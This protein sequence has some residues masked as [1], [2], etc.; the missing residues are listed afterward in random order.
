MSWSQQKER[1]QR[2]TI[3]WL[4][5]FLIFLE[6]PWWWYHHKS[7]FSI[8]SS[9]PNYTICSFAFFCD[10]FFGNVLCSFSWQKI[11]F[12][13]K[14][15]ADLYS[16]EGLHFYELNFVFAAR[17]S[18]I[19][20]LSCIHLWAFTGRWIDYEME[21]CHWRH[22]WTFGIGYWDNILNTFSMVIV[23]ITTHIITTFINMTTTIIII[24]IILVWSQ[25]TVFIWL[26]RTLDNLETADSVQ[27]CN[28]DDL[29]RRHHHLHLHR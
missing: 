18:F 19:F 27:L 20:L 4:C 10:R 17:S 5:L 12:L 14:R 29:R 25:F 6:R 26:E 2:R 1:K 8:K 15:W 3:L 13:Q 9:A 11:C 22:F 24:T 7:S 23:H 16:P 21:M 28:H